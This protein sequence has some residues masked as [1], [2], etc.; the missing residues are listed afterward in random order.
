MEHVCYETVGLGFYVS[1]CYVWGDDGDVVLVG[2]EEGRV[3]SVHWGCRL[4]FFILLSTKGFEGE[5]GVNFIWWDILRDGIKW[6]YVGL[7][8]VAGILSYEY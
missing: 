6:E 8:V 1:Y 5:R 2:E 7:I 4:N 3:E